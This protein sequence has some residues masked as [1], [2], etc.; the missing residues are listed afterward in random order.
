MKNLSVIPSLLAVVF[1]T[2]IVINYTACKKDTEITC[3]LSKTTSA[4]T[5]MDI[6][7]KAVNTGD[8]AISTLTYTVGATTK[9]I[10]NPSLPWTVSVSALDGDGITILA[11]GT[12]KDGSLTISYEGKSGGQEIQGSDYCSHSN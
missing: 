7:F 9:T 5:D 3:N 4:P 2:F 11:N 8:G 12:T 1:L 10:A 6:T